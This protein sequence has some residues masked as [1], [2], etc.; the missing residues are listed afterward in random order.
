METLLAW[1]EGWAQGVGCRFH[2]YLSEYNN[3]TDPAVVLFFLFLL[4]Y[5]AFRLKLIEVARALSIWCFPR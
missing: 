1:F 5:I 3:P 2:Q 4:L